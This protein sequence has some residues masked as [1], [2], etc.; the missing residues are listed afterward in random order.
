MASVLIAA[1]HITHSAAANTYRK[2]PIMNTLS[3]CSADMEAGTAWKQSR[4][5]AMPTVYSMTTCAN[6][7]VRNVALSV[8]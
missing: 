5:A 2:K 8:L 4:A 7:P 3:H 6:N 1:N